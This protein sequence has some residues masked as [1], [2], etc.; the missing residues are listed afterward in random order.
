MEGPAR[1]SI[2]RLPIPQL[3]DTSEVP[4]VDI[5]EEPVNMATPID[6][7]GDP[8]LG[9]RGRASPALLRHCA[10]A[11]KPA[12]E[13]IYDAIEVEELSGHSISDQ[14]SDGAAGRRGTVHRSEK[15]S[16]HHPRY[17]FFLENWLPVA[18]SC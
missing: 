6:A 5:S 13:Q 11:S 15:N 7:D 18:H 3:I 16:K 1:K 17:C 10:A 12:D 4:K 9:H 14:G 2:S 8:L